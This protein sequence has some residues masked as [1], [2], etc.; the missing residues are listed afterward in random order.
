[1]EMNLSA[2]VRRNSEDVRA[3]NS[4]DKVTDGRVV[5]DVSEVNEP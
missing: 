3:E 2:Q 5:R 4:R 1:V